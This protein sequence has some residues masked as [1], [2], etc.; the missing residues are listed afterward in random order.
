MANSNQMP[1]HKDARGFY[2]IET[3]ENCYIYLKNNQKLV[4]RFALPPGWNPTILEKLRDGYDLIWIHKDGAIKQWRLD[5][6][7]NKIWATGTLYGSEA[8][9]IQE[10]F[11][12][13]AL[14]LNSY[15]WFKNEQIA[16]LKKINISYEFVENKLNPQSIQFMIDIIPHIRQLFLTEQLKSSLS[17]LDVGPRT[18]AGSALLQKL[19]S[20]NTN[21]K[22]KMHVTAIDID[23]KFR[24][25]AN[26][27]YPNLEYR[28]GDIYSI[29]NEIWDLVICSH[30]IE[31]V[32]KPKQFLSRLLEL[33]KDYVIIACPYNENENSLVPGH[34]HSIKDSFIDQFDPVIKCVYDGMYWN[35]SLAGI[36]AFQGRGV[37][38]KK[39]EKSGKNK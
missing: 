7:G 4:D 32:P 38:E 15:N 35:N 31:H 18:G 23:D 30:T 9:H 1:L 27:C 10:R 22:I 34:L 19:Y 13:S 6:E 21:S 16:I 33:A 17:V 24:E 8:K 20:P 26:F 28:I 5:R 2:Y 39:E 25:Y 29:K 11:S 12:I 3:K 36:F 14:K 37:K